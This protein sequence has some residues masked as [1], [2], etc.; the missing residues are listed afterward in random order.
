ML[1]I[2]T[3]WNAG[4]HAGW[5]PAAGELVGLGFRHVAL[6][7]PAIQSDAEA[8]GRLVRAARGAVVALFAP[9]PARDAVT[10][11]RGA[12]SLVE[13]RPERREPAVAAALS[14]GRA[15]AAA[16]TGLVVVRAGAIPVLDAS[17]EDRW[18][19]RF[20]REGLTDALRDEVAAACAEMR[21]DRP[22]F[23]EAL[24]RSLWDL[25]RALPDTTW[26]VETPASVAGLPFPDEVEPLHSELK[27]RRVGIWHDTAHAARLGALGAAPA[28][29][30][31]ERAAGATRGVTLSDWSPHGGRTPPGAGHVDW[32]TLR[33]QL[34]GAMVRVLRVA[35]EF[36]A[37]FLAEAAR[38]AERRTS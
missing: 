31:I 22:R 33:G 9:A 18:T 35:P 29:A 11:A 1:A 14:A 37:A 2:S 17:R 32:T 25:S 27:G 7:G 28:S 36:P 23:L 6:D 5:E 38:D 8:A 4:R 19:E 16:G 15:A 24:C 3:A 34:T 21:R 10:D 13:V 20:G 26:L 30:W 12:A